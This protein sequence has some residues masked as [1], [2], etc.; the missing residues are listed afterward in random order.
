MDDEALKPPVTPSHIIIRQ[1]LTIKWSFYKTYDL[2]LEAKSLKTIWFNN[3][4][5][6]K[7]QHYGQHMC[8]KKKTKK[9]NRAKLHKNLPKIH[10]CWQDCVLGHVPSSFEIFFRSWVLTYTRYKVL[11]IQTCTEIVSCLI[12][13]PVLSGKFSLPLC[14]FSNHSNF[15]NGPIITQNRKTYRKNFHQAMLKAFSFEP[16]SWLACFVFASNA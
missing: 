3:F 10:F 2:T 9:K 16:F 13:S 4:A 15:Y 1:Q 11:V 6:S 8:K 7:V 14:V 12:L 5:F